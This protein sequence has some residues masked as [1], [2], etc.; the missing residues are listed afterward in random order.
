M[1]EPVSAWGAIPQKPMVG[2]KLRNDLFAG[3]ANKSDLRKQVA[4]T[5]Q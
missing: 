2:D 3:L 1:L 4:Q 5:G